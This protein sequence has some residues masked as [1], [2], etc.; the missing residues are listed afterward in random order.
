MFA[1]DHVH[2]L[3]RDRRAVGD[4]LTQVLGAR[5]LRLEETLTA[6]NWE[7]ELDGTRILVREQEEVEAAQPGAVRREG[8]DH[9]GLKVADIEE[10]VSR[11]V[12]AGF[13]LEKGPIRPRADL[14]VAFLSGPGGLLIEI[15]QRG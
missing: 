14:S 13:V 11:L 9:L 3:C 10:A 8:L 2:I 4:A 12:G 15:L 5:Q 6:P 7:F 1:F